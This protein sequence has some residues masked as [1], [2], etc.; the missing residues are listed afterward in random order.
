[1]PPEVLRKLLPYLRSRSY[2]VELQKGVG[3]DCKTILDVGCGSDSPIK[4]FSGTLYLVG[5][6]AYKPSLEISCKKNIHNKY[7]NMTFSELDKFG[8]CSFDCVVALDVIEHLKKDEGRRFLN[9]VERIAKK[10]I[11]ILTTNGFVKQNEYDNNPLQIHR[12]GWTKKEM[13]LRGYKVTG[14]GGLRVLRGE[15]ALTRFHPE[16]LWEL[17]SILT[18]YFVRNYSQFAFEILCVKV[19]DLE[20]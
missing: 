3:S 7:Y 11:I 18:Q 16:P 9:N 12:S 1:M 8:S 6:D 10:K 2:L 14:I 5:I 17:I 4:I 19:K 13:R 15:R 20:S